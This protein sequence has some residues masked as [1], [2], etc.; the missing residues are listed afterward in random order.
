MKT[1]RIGSSLK[2]NA[3][4]RIALG[5][6]AANL[7]K[8][9]D[10]RKIESNGL[11]VSTRVLKAAGIVTAVVVSVV[12]LW[13]VVEVLLLIFAGTLLAIFLQGLGRWVGRHAR[14]SHGWSLAIVIF[15][16]TAAGG[17]LIWLLAPD[18]IEQLGG[19]SDDLLRSLEG[20][21]EKVAHYPWGR[22]LFQKIPEPGTFAGS[23]GGMIK[24]A[25]GILSTTIGAVS[26]LIVVVFFG[27]YLAADPD[28][29]IEGF[30]R[31]IPS[32]RRDRAREV[33]GA[34]GHT[35]HWWLI[36]RMFDMALVGALTWL[37]LW[38]LGVPLA[39]T[40]GIIAALLTFIPNIGPILSALPAML[41]AYGQSQVLVLYVT[42]L[43]IAIQTVES[44]LITPLVQQRTVS[45]PPALTFAAQIVMG[46]L[47]GIPGLILATPFAAAMLVPV[48]M[49]YV[50]DVLGE[51][52][53]T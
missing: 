51:E 33:L 16:L 34:V 50:E 1:S 41:L 42:L 19:L 12:L 37:G 13:Y 40:L 17:L 31:L 20:I 48:K 5:S 38:L 28:L 49:L 25:A 36:G 26:S 18:L 8:E 39:L 52:I 46:L 45:L 44:Y 23:L 47:L 29:Y 9:S 22:S 24:K 35:L 3:R 6:R 2:R 10:S 30:L 21:R 32:G 7:Q 27:I 43:Y 53:E 11:G 15:T 4:T 14:L